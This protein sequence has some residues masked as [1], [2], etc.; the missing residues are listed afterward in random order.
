MKR[1]A[2]TLLCGALLLTFAG[3]GKEETKELTEKE[4]AQTTAESVQATEETKAVDLDAELAGYETLQMTTDTFF[5]EIGLTADQLPQNQTALAIRFT[6]REDMAILL[7]C[8]A[9]GTATVSKIW[10]R[11]QEANLSD[12]PQEVT[13]ADL[14]DEASDSN[15]FAMAES[16]HYTLIKAF[17]SPN[18]SDTLHVAFSDEDHMA[19]K[20]KCTLGEYACYLY[21]DLKEDALTYRAY[22][23]QFYPECVQAVGALIRLVRST[24][25]FWSEAGSVEIV[26]GE[27]AFRRE[28]YETVS[29]DGRLLSDLEAEKRLSAGEE[30]PYSDCETEE[31]V[32]AYNLQHESKEA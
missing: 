13:F 16:E 8:K 23:A 30:S 24:D 2:C 10:C 20:T 7:Q 27:A 26:N 3:C 32:I 1:F 31:D 22:N 12:D 21:I 11:G 4:T 6:D 17:S 29:T 28:K 14:Q 19:Q 25:D 18:M 15:P 9:A 5:G